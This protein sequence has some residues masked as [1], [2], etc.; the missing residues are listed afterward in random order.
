MYSSKEPWIPE[1]VDKR[2]FRIHSGKDHGLNARRQKQFLNS[3]G[4]SDTSEIEQMVSVAE[5]VDTSKKDHKSRTSYDSSFT[6]EEVE[7]LKR[8][9]ERNSDLMHKRADVGAKVD[10]ALKNKR[11]YCQT[12]GT[13]FENGAAQYDIVDRPMLTLKKYLQQQLWFCES[14]GTT[15]SDVNSVDLLSPSF[16]YSSNGIRVKVLVGVESERNVN[17]NDDHGININTRIFSKCNYFMDGIPAEPFVAQDGGIIGKSG[18]VTCVSNNRGRY[19]GA[20]R[21]FAKKKKYTVTIWVGPKTQHNDANGT[22]GDYDD[23]VSNR[24]RWPVKLRAELPVPLFLGALNSGNRTFSDMFVTQFLADKFLVNGGEDTNGLSLHEDEIEFLLVEKRG[25]TPRKIAQAKQELEEYLESQLMKHFAADESDLHETEVSQKAKQLYKDVTGESFDENVNVL[26]FNGGQLLLDGQDLSGFSSPGL[27]NDLNILGYDADTKFGIDTVEDKL[28]P[29]FHQQ[30]LRQLPWGVQNCRKLVIDG[31]SI[32]GVDKRWIDLDNTV[33]SSKSKGDK[34]SSSDSSQTSEE[35]SSSNTSITPDSS[36]DGNLSS[37]GGD[38]LKIKSFDLTDEDLV[39]VMFNLFSGE[40]SHGSN[41]IDD[42]PGVAKSESADEVW[43]RNPTFDRVDV[44]AVPCG[45]REFVLNHRFPRWVQA[46]LRLAAGASAR[47]GQ[48]GDYMINFDSRRTENNEDS[49]S[50][51]HIPFPSPSDMLV[52]SGGEMAY[53]NDFLLSE[54]DPRP[55]MTTSV[56]GPQFLPPL[57]EVV[58]LPQA[59]VDQVT[60]LH[61]R[62]DFTKSAAELEFWR[63]VDLVY[64]TE[65]DQVLGSGF[66]LTNNIEN[67]ESG[68]RF[69]NASQS[70]DEAYGI[71]NEFG[72]Q[73]GSQIINKSNDKQNSLAYIHGHWIPVSKF[74][75]E[76]TDHLSSG[77]VSSHSP[78]GASTQRLSSTSQQVQSPA[79]TKFS[80]FLKANPNAFFVPHRIEQRYLDTRGECFSRGNRVSL[81]NRAFDVCDVDPCLQQT[82][83]FT[84]KVNDTGFM[85]GVH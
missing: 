74:G 33:S 30:F 72:N 66:D 39:K 77:S 23:D 24:D 75:F 9:R 51:N 57:H 68:S 71:W 52:Y 82:N 41:E 76:D 46:K 84:H 50:T 4:Q 18:N 83:V 61:G 31:S 85:S 36:S 73:F 15:T 58:P 56:R 7:E 29:M 5:P 14:F 40:D 47:D 1:T 54:Y 49:D 25:I 2:K 19:I 79:L 78:G 17:P 38:L 64:F 48:T 8:R 13:T 53:G 20:L 11:G 80:D 44:Q 55:N 60:I 21:S 12:P 6:K 10:V 35:S 27:T 3:L 62:K 67:Y 26:I 69:S 16:P 81:H 43:M 42:P 32:M 59:D 37:S 34:S 22:S 70:L 45:M 28:S 63:N 65:A